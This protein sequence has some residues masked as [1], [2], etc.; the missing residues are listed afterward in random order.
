MKA[1]NRNLMAANLVLQ[2]TT[3]TEKDVSQASSGDSSLK[4]DAPSRDST[5]ETD[6]TESLP[7]NL[8]Q[9]STQSQMISTSRRIIRHPSSYGYAELQGQDIFHQYLHHF[10]D[11]EKMEAS[12]NPPS[13]QI[14]KEQSLEWDNHE[15]LQMVYGGYRPVQSTPEQIQ[16]RKSEAEVRR[17]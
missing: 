15:E 5:T 4:S 3:R 6:V 13:L 17:I 2:P 12:Q 11:F 1:S 9:N 14:R 16:L 10:K 8:D 7:S